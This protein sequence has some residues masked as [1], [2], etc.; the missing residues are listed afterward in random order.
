[1]DDGALNLLLKLYE[2][3]LS[4]GRT[5][6]I[7]DF[8][9]LDLFASHPNTY[10]FLKFAYFDDAMF[11]LE[12]MVLAKHEY[13][14][15]VE[16]VQL[17]DQQLLKGLTQ[18]E[19]EKLREYLQY[20]C[21]NEGE[22]IIEKGSAAENIFFL[23]TGRVAIVDTSENKRDFTLAIINSGNSFGEM[24]L[25]DKQRR[26]ANAIAQTKVTCF[27]MIYEVLDNIE[28]LAG[29]KIKILTNLGALLSDRLRTANKEI[30]SFA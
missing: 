5:M 28:S 10:D 16:P 13:V 2:Q 30:A 21:F 15:K 19:L 9:Q 23:E 4:F 7:T 26:S 18:E 17:T 22:I 27:I 25:L 8:H 3:F 11:C 20:K 6:F 12:N 1:M 24:A 14:P 29:I